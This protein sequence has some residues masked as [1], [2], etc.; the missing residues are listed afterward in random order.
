M[1]DPVIK[2]SVYRDL[3]NR[4]AGEPDDGPMAWAAH[5]E[6]RKILEEVLGDDA[7]AVEDWGVTK[8]EQRPHELADLIIDIVK[9]ATPVGVALAVGTQVLKLI[10]KPFEK[11][12]DA[13]VQKIFGRL[14][15]AFR[16]KRIGDFTMTL[17][18]GTRVQCPPGAKIVVT[19]PDGK[20]LTM[21]APA[22]A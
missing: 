4:A 11:K 21:E 22:S 19:L 9:D 13:A 18:D 10:A 14:F 20:T 2:L 17:P 1:A 16:K 15:D 3:S 5:R 6:R 8:D 12:I 7:F